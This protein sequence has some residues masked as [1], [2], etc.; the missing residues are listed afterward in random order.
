MLVDVAESVFAAQVQAA[1]HELVLYRD[2]KPVLDEGG[3][4][5]TVLRG[6][7]AVERIALTHLDHGSLQDRQVLSSIFDNIVDTTIRSSNPEAQLQLKAL[8]RRGQQLGDLN[9][10]LL[11]YRDMGPNPFYNCWFLS[12]GQLLVLLDH[13]QSPAD[14]WTEL[15][16]T[17]GMSFGSLDFY[18]ELSEMRRVAAEVA[19]TAAPAS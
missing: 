3:T 13:V 15:Q 2:E 1:R 17:R 6:D 18:F 10:Q 4:V 9:R 16:R 12:L 5:R 19:A 14:L 8:E 7:R 11:Q